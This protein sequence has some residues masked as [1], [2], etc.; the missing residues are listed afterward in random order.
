MFKRTLSVKL[1]SA[2]SRFPVVALTGPRQ[3][4]KTTLAKEILCSYS[5]ALY[6][7]MELPSDR[8]KLNEPELFLNSRKHQLVVIDEVQQHPGLFPVLRGL[9]DQERRPGRFLLLGSASPELIN[10]SAESLAGRIHYLEMTPLTLAEVGH[11]PEILQQLWLRGGF[12]ES[13]QAENDLDA[14]EWRE[15]FIRTYL[16]RDIPNLGFRLPAQSLRRFWQMLAHWHGQIWNASTL[17]QSLAVS[18]QTANRYLDILGDAFVAR[19]LMPYAANLG[20]RLIKAPKV[21]LRDTGLLHTLLNIARFDLL[22]G[23]PAIG[24]SWEGFV[25]EQ[26]L[27]S[28]NPAEA[29]Y[30]RT[31]AG[32]ELDLVLQLRGQPRLIAVEIKYSLAPKLSKGFWNSLDDLQ[33]D[34]AFVIYAGKEIYPI[35]Q[36][37]IAWPAEQIPALVEKL[38]Q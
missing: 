22:E 24:A 19:R 35:E 12:P 4:G 17:A 29:F 38:S 16:E 25:I 8:A 36:R 13:F 9:V 1:S 26:L 15:G 2:L 3:V 11:T 10:R 7:D 37:V 6:L 32:A 30:Y 18:P 20:K 27:S 21:Y 5:Q 14:F 23:H 34:Q 33:I 28:L 31:V